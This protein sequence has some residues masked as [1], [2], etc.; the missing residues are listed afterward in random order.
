MTLRLTFIVVVGCAALSAALIGPSWLDHRQNPD[1]AVSARVVNFDSVRINASVE[2]LLTIRNDGHATIT[3]RGSSG[4]L[5][6]FASVCPRR[7]GRRERMSNCGFSVW[8]A[9]TC[10]TLKPG[11][12]CAVA[13]H[14]T[15]RTSR[16]YHARFCFKYAANGQR[17]RQTE[18]CVTVT[19]KG[20][21]G[22]K[23]L[24]AR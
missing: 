14:F 7:L 9:D 21:R 4:A 17:W 13:I 22:G 2:Q 20:D 11:S 10:E 8:P 6:S 12:S 16:P 1:V 15:P 24:S 3:A 23:S 5:R 18:T 19:G